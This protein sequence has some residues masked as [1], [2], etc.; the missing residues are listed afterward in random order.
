MLPLTQAEL[1]GLFADGPHHFKMELRRN[2]PSPWLDPFPADPATTAVLAERIHWPKENPQH[3]A[4]S[5]PSAEPLLAATIA[6]RQNLGRLRSS[7]AEG[8]V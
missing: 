1:L 3:H 5:S 7:S 2:D 4:V 6:W 8:C